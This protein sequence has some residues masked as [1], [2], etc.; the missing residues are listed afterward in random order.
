MKRGKCMEY[1]IFLE[2][3]EV[4]RIRG[5]RQ[6]TYIEWLAGCPFEEGWIY[7]LYLQETE[8]SEGICLGVMMPEGDR[9]VLKKRIHK[10]KAESNDLCGII[11]RSRPGEEAPKL[12]PKTSVPPNL[13]GLPFGISALESI[14]SCGGFVDTVFAASGGKKVQREGITYYLAPGKPGET[15]GPTAFFC[16]LTWIPWE[17]SGWWVLCVGADGQPFA[18]RK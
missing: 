3:T 10:G 14:E 8:N 2:D 16:L 1:P 9:F 15:L 6:G 5:Q 18:L 12:Q 17:D 11:L 4:G 7:R 13:D